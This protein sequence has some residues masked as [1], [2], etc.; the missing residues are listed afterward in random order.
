MGVQSNSQF[1]RRRVQ[2]IDLRRRARIVIGTR[3]YAGWIDDISPAGAQLQTLTSIG[4]LGSVFLRLPDLRALQ[5]TLHWSN[6]HKAGVS[7]ELPLS[8]EEFSGWVSGRAEL[9]PHMRR[10]ATADI[11]DIAA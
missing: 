1:E 8:I 2:R 5:C 6:S 11:T 10:L 3:H 4:P 9:T 7:F